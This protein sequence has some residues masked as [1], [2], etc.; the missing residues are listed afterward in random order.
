MNYLVYETAEATFGRITATGSALRER[1]ARMQAFGAREVLCG[2]QADEDLHRVVM[3]PDGPEVVAR[4]AMPAFSA[5]SI[6]A[7]GIDAAV[8]DLGGVE[9]ERLTIN[10]VPAAVSGGLARLTADVATVYEVKVVAWPYLDQTVQIEA[11]A[12]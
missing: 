3:G 12:P 6:R 1:D 11:V 7:D 2:V 8:L 4:P 5:T 9:I 10:G